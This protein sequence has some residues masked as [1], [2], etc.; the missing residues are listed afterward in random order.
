MRI[1]PQI[2]PDIVVPRA[3]YYM[4]VYVKE[5]KKECGINGQ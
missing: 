4:I 1:P 3:K 5:R 2:T